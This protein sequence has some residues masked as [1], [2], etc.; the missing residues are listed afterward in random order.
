[1]PA[2]DPLSAAA[3]IGSYA[4][5]DVRDEREFMSG[6]FEGSGHLPAAELNERR[7]E[8]PPR[9]AHILVVAAGSANAREAAETLEG[10]GYRDVAWLDGRVSES[11]LDLV[12]T[13]AKPLWRPSP[14]LE[15]VL[16]QLPDPRQGPRRALD[17]AAGAGRESV[18]M[19]L[20]GYEVEAWDHDR[21]TL[22]KASA[23]ALRHGVKIETQTR[24]L[25]TRDPRLPVESH[26]VVMVFR[27]LHR[28]LFPQIARAVAMGGVVIYETYLKGQERFGRPKHPRFLLDRDELPRHF[29]GFVVEHYE[30]QTPDSGP[31]LARL[32]AR[33]PGGSSGEISAP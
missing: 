27:F 1:M 6:H 3:S 10:L 15:Q 29:P 18:F 4:L 13:P 2:L 28:P 24:D 12:R 20:R 19:A 31:M 14:F 22:E 26:D 21:G 7:G 23:M 8:L 30:E 11:D 33:K 16:P 17:L 25:E 32:L 9:D 5:L